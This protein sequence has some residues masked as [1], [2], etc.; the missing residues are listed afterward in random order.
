M[1]EPDE[2]SVS[3]TLKNGVAVTIRT[4]RASDRDKIATA[5][6]HLDRDSIYTRLFSYRKEL[7]EAGLDRI[8]A[9]DPARDVM[10]VV[11]VGAGDQETVI[12]SG[13]FVARADDGRAR[14]G[15]IAFMVEEDYHG[16]GIAGR[17]LHHLADV[18]RSK[19][20]AAFEA[21]V[22]GENKAML[23]VFARSGLP[24]RQRR[25]GGVVHVTLSLVGPSA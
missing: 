4:L 2:F 12:A 15:E 9:V 19:G 7:T 22:L 13:R 16:Q 23:A 3:E 14:S 20:V 8:M 11:T 21:E 25:D 10:L 24:M 5:V 6:R 18:A 17:L 1:T